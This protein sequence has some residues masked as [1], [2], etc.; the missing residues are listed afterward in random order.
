MNIKNV[1]SWLIELLNPTSYKNDSDKTWDN[2]E[3]MLKQT[4]C[5]YV[6]IPESFCM[7]VSKRKANIILK[8]LNLQFKEKQCHPW[9]FNWLKRLKIYDIIYQNKY[10]Q[11]V[12]NSDAID[13]NGKKIYKLKLIWLKP[14]N[15]TVKN[16]IGE[17]IYNE[18]TKRKYILTKDD[19]KYIIER[20][21]IIPVFDI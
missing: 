2:I 19:E 3:S 21:G 20:T 16:K 13:D 10:I 11:A 9:C 18:I 14:V 8:K 7:W 5:D 6:R 17:T 15:V 1:Q 4:D 12:L